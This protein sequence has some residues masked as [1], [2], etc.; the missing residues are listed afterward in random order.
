VTRWQLLGTLQRLGWQVIDADTE[1]RKL[2]EE[3]GVCGGEGAV[4]A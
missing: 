2:L 1:N 3:C 4:K